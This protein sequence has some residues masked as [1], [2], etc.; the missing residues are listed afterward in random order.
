MVMALATPR[1][2]GSGRWHNPAAAASVMIELAALLFV[3]AVVVVPALLKN[4]VGMRA[5]AT[6]LAQRNLS[7]ATGAVFVLT[8]L[9]AAHNTVRLDPLMTMAALVAGAVALLYLLVCAPNSRGTQVDTM[10]LL[11]WGFGALGCAW[12]WLG[13]IFPP[14]LTPFVRALLAALYSAGCVA[15]AVRVGLMLRTVPPAKLPDP[16]TV[17]MPMAGPASIS[18]AHGAM[19]RRGSAARP[20]FR[21]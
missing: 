15:C 2:S 17:G 18:A 12:L 20:K 10:E 9:F 4:T 8:F 3:L 11:L 13:M 6:P 1:R 21:T 7:R 5:R 14:F 16:A 19:S